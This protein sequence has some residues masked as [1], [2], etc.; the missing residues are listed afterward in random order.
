MR[1]AGTYS[2]RLIYSSA[3]EGLQGTLYQFASLYF[4]GSKCH[5][6]EVIAGAVA[7]RK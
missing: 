5:F 1:I 6:S 7:S 2:K 4:T 3:I